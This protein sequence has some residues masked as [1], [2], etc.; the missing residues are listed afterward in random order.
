MHRDSA[1]IVPQIDIMDG[2][3]PQNRASQTAAA[4]KQSR[5]NLSPVSPV[6]GN[7]PDDL[8]Q[9]IIEHTDLELK[10]SPNKSP[11]N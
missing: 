11:Q 7:L 1:K 4:A 8:R 2:I 5:Q 9:F 3:E 6:E 10:L